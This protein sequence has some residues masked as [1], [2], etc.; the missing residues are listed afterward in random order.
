MVSE[1]RGLDSLDDILSRRFSFALTVILV[2]SSVPPVKFYSDRSTL[3]SQ[4]YRY[5][6]EWHAYFEWSN[7]FI[8]FIMLTVNL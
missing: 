2:L 8:S 6:T 4:I 5:K 3:T 7:T 1:N